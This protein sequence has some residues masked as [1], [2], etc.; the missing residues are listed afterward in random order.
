MT[1][2]LACASLLA[3]WLN[4]RR[5]RA[6]FAIWAC[7]NA[8][9]CAIDLAHGVPAQALLMASYAILAVHGWRSWGRTARAS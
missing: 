5:R 9:W 8:A 1:W 7:T 4:I 2:L 6:C 3:T